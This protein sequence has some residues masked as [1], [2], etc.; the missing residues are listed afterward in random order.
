MFGAILQDMKHSARGMGNRPGFSAMMVLTLALGMGATTA[1]FSV[2]YSVL[3]KPLPYPDPDRLVSVFEV[4]RRGTFARLADPNFNDFRDQN[5][6]FV[7][8]A[9]YN[10]FMANV[11]GP[12]G[13]TRTG[14]SY[15][16]RDF[17]RVLGVQPAIGRGFAPED[18]HPGAAPVVLVS[19]RYWKEYLVSVREFSALHLR[20]EDRV[21]SIAGILPELFEFPAKT[22]LWVPSE[23][24]PDNTSRTSHNYSAIGRLRPG[25]S[26]PQASTD[27][28]AIAQRIVQQSPEQNDYLLRSAAAVSMQ[29]S[30]TGR[31]RSVL[32]ILLGA[33]GF[34]LLVGCAN[35]AN[36]LLIQASK[37]GRELSIRN[38]LGAGRGRLMGQFIAETLLLSGLSCVA[39]VAIA[40]GLLRVLLVLAPS[41]LPRLSEV[42]ISWPVLAFTAG[43]S[44][45]AALGLGITTAVR[46]TSGT[47]GGSLIEGGR[48]SVGTQRSERA[49]R[50]IVAAQLA[51]TL[52]LLTG[53]GL[54]GRSLLRVLSVDPGFRTDHIVAID[55]ELQE[56]AD[57]KAQGRPALRARRSHLVDRLIQRL[58]TIPGVQQVAAVNAVPMDG[59][60]PDGMFLAVTPQENPKDFNE[61]RSLAKQASRRGTADFCAASPEYLH[62]LGI[63]LVSG[64]FF[65]Q[66]DAFDAPHTAVITESLARVRWPHQDPIGQT[67]QFGNMD[68]DLN[69]LTIV[70]IAGDTHEYGLEQP[71]RP[72]LYVNFLQRPRSTFSIVMHS[73]MDTAQLTS[74]A[75][76]IVHEEVPDTAPR[77]RTFQQIYSTSLG[78]R[79]F[80]LTLVGVFALTALLLAVG[81]V[82]GVVAYN[83]AQR[84]Q[85][86]GVR[87]ALGARNADVLGLILQQG[88]TTTLIGVAIGIVGS[89]VIARAIQSLLYGV[90]P[91]DPLTFAGVALLLVCV[92]GLAC[93]VPARRATE[94]DP[95]V[96]LR[97]D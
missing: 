77:F 56:S 42:T 28:A 93:Y 82:Y 54:L 51:M 85:E 69:L 91:T 79:R 71:A 39:G 33:V 29:E 32:Y 35:T 15:V 73:D 7:A 81:G 64:R 16:T 57:V 84:T 66:R 22:D 97:S 58:H 59:G 13:P 26:V 70:G 5:H 8:M 92:A 17:F 68:G 60:L 18:A 36:F 49:G 75:R 4:N 41:D 47:S 94:V 50:A 9:K 30:M 45:L 6:T 37:R 40:V 76:A 61:Y 25:V 44:L 96:A 53:A 3:L 48:G 10:G 11:V 86:I 62:A 23:L 12:A 67:I 55:L 24:D 46:V 31:I 34:L 78:S 72:T 38:A 74:A 89:F 88:M 90:T 2:V 65:D 20:I 27:L 87:M 83:V 52:A 43:I 14:V 63:P 1:I 21:Y 19:A 80:N 95:M